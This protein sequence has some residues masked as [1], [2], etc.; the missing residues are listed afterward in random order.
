VC[1]ASK[2]RV[3]VDFFLR[4]THLSSDFQR[5]A[6]HLQLRM[7][8]SSESGVPP[9]NITGT[10][11]ESTAETKPKLTELLKADM[12]LYAQCLQHG[13]NVVEDGG[14]MLYISVDTTVSQ[15]FWHFMMGEFF[16]ILHYIL[17]RQ[18]EGGATTRVH[19]HKERANFPLNSFYDEICVGT[20]LDI[21]VSEKRMHG[22]RY[23]SHERWDFDGGGQKLT[24]VAEFLKV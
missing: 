7:S 20:N 23:A 15:H 1:N 18:G 2:T 3:I 14:N 8:R 9:F 16:P 5:L 4:Q 11:F 21:M 24:R 19:I 12:D 22:K 13:Q 6:E 17:S 10:R